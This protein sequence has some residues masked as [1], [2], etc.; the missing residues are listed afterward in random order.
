MPTMSI[1]ISDSLREF[2]KSRVKSGD[3]NNESE[4]V[5]DLVRKDREREAAETQLLRVLDDARKSGITDMSVPDIIR[6]VQE[7]MRQHGE[8]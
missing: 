8:I 2:I 3:Y 5:R 7:E 1:S 6:E 4:Y